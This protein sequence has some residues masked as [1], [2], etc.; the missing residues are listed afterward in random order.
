MNVLVIPEDFRNDQYILAPV[1]SGLFNLCGKPNAN[2]R[3][4][5]DPLLG[6]VTEAMKQE[7]LEE[8]FERYDGMIDIFVLCVD[9]D[10]TPGREAALRR[11]E[12]KYSTGGRR[13]FAVAAIE[14]L[15]AWLL[16]GCDLPSRWR[17]Q[18][19]RRERDVKEA[20]FIPYARE[21]K[22]EFSPGQGRK[23]LGREVRGQI[24]RILQRCPEELGPLLGKL[25]AAV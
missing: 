1:F 25:Q 15:E 20:Y 3:V 21:R 18:D 8:I 19:I 12:E 13:F 10:A 23:I 16:A 14:E 7:R 17:W 2:V 4:C 6:G 24:N 11:L 9:R 22:V 5:L